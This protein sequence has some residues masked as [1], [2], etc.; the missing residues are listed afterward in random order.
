MLSV[1]VSDDRIQVCDF[2]VREKEKGVYSTQK[3][4]QRRTN[5]SLLCSPVPNSLD[6]PCAV[7]ASK[8]TKRISANRKRLSIN[9]ENV[10][11][12]KNVPNSRSTTRS[13]F[14]VY[15]TFPNTFTLSLPVTININQLKLPV[16]D[17]LFL[18]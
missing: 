15:N 7:C 3:H 14:L 1:E 18:H 17:S 11:N 4:E 16:Y 5:D 2:V 9:T 8:N 13:Q 10:I 12:P 6:L